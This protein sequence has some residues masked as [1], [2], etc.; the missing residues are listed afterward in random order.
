MPDR[1]NKL[2][3]PFD[4][5]PERTFRRLLRENRTANMG[6]NNNDPPALPAA[7]HRRLR[8]FAPASSS[9]IH[10]AIRM[11]AIGAATFTI[12]PATIT[13]M[14]SSYSF[15]GSS[16]EDPNKHIADFLEICETFKINNVSDEAIRLRLFPFSLRDKAKT[17]LQSEPHH[18][19][20]SWND[21]VTKFLDKFFPPSRTVKLKTDINNFVQYEGENIYEAW[22]RYK[23]MLRKC[24]HH[25]LE[26]WMI[27]TQF[28]NG[29]SASN[30]TL[31][32]A[33]AGGA[34]DDK[35]EDEA[36]ALIET[37]AR[38]TYQWPN[39]RITLKKPAA[40]VHE[41]GANSA[42]EARF[43]SQDKKIDAMLQIM[44]QGQNFVNAVQ[45][46]VC[47]I[48]E[49]PHS[50]VECQAPNP[51]APV[52]Q[53]NYVNQNQNHN[54]Y[55]NSYNPNWRNHPNLSWKNNQNVLNPPSIK[56]LWKTSRIS[57]SLLQ[58]H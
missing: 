48:C 45:S 39:E 40:A 43:S 49:G 5:E 50:G 23:E 37:I 36:Y 22:E 10:S 9:G 29:L 18:S 25:G 58:T 54:Q 19:I 20:T 8:E 44:T 12:M 32:D 46:V 33:T 47:E 27:A 15:G 38:K 41:I 11:P 21:L 4:P 1:T 16:T 52:E 56:E 26:K 53:V 30:R 13:M 7:V 35:Y 2:I 14:Q 31:V 24:P 17:W 3:L 55:G 57:L 6:D 28:Y 42:L 51:F 34:F